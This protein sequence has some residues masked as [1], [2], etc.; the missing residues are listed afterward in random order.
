MGG[1]DEG[2]SRMELL[3]RLLQR[4]DSNP[5]LNGRIA[6]HGG[7]AINAYLLDLPRLSV[8]IDLSY[9]GNI[10]SVSMGRERAEV[11]DA[12]RR[13]GESMGLSASYGKDGHAGRTV[14]FKG[15]GVGVKAD[16]NFMNRVVP[17]DPVRLESHVIPGTTFTV[18][19]P[20][21]LYGGKIRALLGRTA[22][23]DL[24][25][26]SMLGRSW[27]GMPWGVPAEA[28]AHL[29]LRRAPGGGVGPA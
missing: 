4:I 24:Y 23:R 28:Q 7:T 2:L 5:R 16:V 13:S 3:T 29:R 9:L 15:D 10:D 22:I 1:W 19:S 6:L 17:H 8:D 25:D 14:R 27:D 11:L 20:Y 21:D 18:L 12:V 26:I